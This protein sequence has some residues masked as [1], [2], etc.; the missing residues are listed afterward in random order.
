MGLVG[1]IMEVLFVWMAWRPQGYA[2]VT[3][4][5]NVRVQ[6]LQIRKK[7]SQNLCQ[8][9]TISTVPT[10]S[11]LLLPLP[12]HMSITPPPL[13]PEGLG[14]SPLA[15]TWPFLQAKQGTFYLYQPLP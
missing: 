8:W 1:R 10:S 14:A 7:R 4:F 9:F 6:M 5:R 2:F 11:R 13:H 3:I 12:Q 15:A